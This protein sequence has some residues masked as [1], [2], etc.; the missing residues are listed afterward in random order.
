M[1]DRETTRVEFSPSALACLIGSFPRLESDRIQD[2]P[3][4]TNAARHDSPLTIPE[5][6][7]D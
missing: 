6:H 7:L 3:I 2:E 1:E 5:Y 4:W